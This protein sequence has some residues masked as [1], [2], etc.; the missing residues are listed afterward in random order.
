MGW[1]N[2]GSI[3]GGQGAR[4]RVSLVLRDCIWNAPRYRF[5]SQP[6]TIPTPWVLLHVIWS[7][8]LVLWFYPG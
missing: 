2:L 1:G 4:A 3:L 5:S 6:L 8:S 7:I